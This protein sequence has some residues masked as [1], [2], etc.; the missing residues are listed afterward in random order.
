MAER[1]PDKV[2]A[3]PEK[4]LL[5]NVTV[6]DTLSK[7]S[8]QNGCWMVY[9]STDYVFDGT[10]PPYNPN[11]E[12]NPLNLY[13]RMKRDAE[14][15][16]WKNQKDAGVL[17]VPV[18]Y[19]NVEYLEES[20]VTV[21]A[22]FVLNKTQV[23]L[24]HWQNRYPTLIDDVAHACV[25]LAERKLEHCGLYGTWHMSG[26]ERFT[27]YEIAVEIAKVFGLSH[28]HILPSAIPNPK[29]PQDAQFNCVALDVMGLRKKTPFTLA[30]RTILEPWMTQK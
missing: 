17:R 18:L 11:A 1:R 29:V 26:P 2:D 19:G 7:I 16:V 21:L 9:I 25:G 8:S 10:N 4:A 24:D 28:D 20:A 3:D 27:K 13:G 15:A 23:E 12:P 22:K 5:L 14:L 6:T 30:I